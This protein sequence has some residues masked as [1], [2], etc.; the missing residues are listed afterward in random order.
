MKPAAGLLLASVV[1]SGLAANPLSLNPQRIPSQSVTGH[2]R[3]VDIAHRADRPAPSAG[4]NITLVDIIEAAPCGEVDLQ[5]NTL[6]AGFSALLTI[7]DVSDPT[8]PV[9]LSDFQVTKYIYDIEVQGS[10]VYLMDV[11]GGI[12][13]VDV[14]DL[15]DPILDTQLPAIGNQEGSGITWHE[16]YLYL[17]TDDHGMIIY[18]ASDP[19]NP[20]QVGHLATASRVTDIAV[21]GNSAYMTAFSD[22]LF[23]LDVTDKS[24]PV[25]VGHYDGMEWIA[26]S[27]DV[28]R[29]HA[30]VTSIFDNDGLWI[31][32][33]SDPANPEQIGFKY[34]DFY[35]SD[36]VVAGDYAYVVN[37][38]SSNQELAVIDVSDPTIPTR[39][40]GLS[41]AGGYEIAVGG[42]KAYVAAWYD[43]LE[44]VDVSVPSAPVEIGDYPTLGYFNDIVAISGYLAMA[45]DYQL[46]MVEIDNPWHQYHVGLTSGQDRVYDVEIQGGYAY[47][48]SCDG[49]DGPWQG[50]HVVDILDP[51][52]PTY[53]SSLGGYCIYGLSVEGD[54]VYF[55]SGEVFNVVDISDSREPAIVGSLPVTYRAFRVETKGGVAYVVSGDDGLLVIDV[56]NP[57]EPQEIGVYNP[58]PAVSDVAVKGDFAYLA[59]SSYSSDIGFRVIDISVPSDP[60]GVGSYDTGGGTQTIALTGNY[61]YVG[62]MS[63]SC[64]WIY[65]ISDPAVPQEAGYYETGGTNGRAAFS[66]PFV[67]AQSSLHGGL[68]ILQTDLFSDT[69]SEKPPAMSLGQNY[70]NPFVPSTKISFTMPRAARAVLKVYDIKGRLVRT[71]IDEETEKGE[72]TVIWDG[73]DDSGRPVA[74]GVYFYQL[75]ADGQSQAKKMIL[76]K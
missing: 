26:Y 64:L 55:V 47:L 70:P 3:P 57:T 75:K 18:D 7:I 35:P 2:S 24:N 63:N 29:D 45:R 51:A 39:V 49:W 10:I 11:D 33:V 1:F 12:W 37:I 15:Y 74:S 68:F 76:L 62:G 23:V 13:V 34:V 6:F 73:N 19:S 67:F 8:Q 58:G 22:G 16:S 60:V 53:V 31:F 30:Y 48:A 72:S 44:V 17:C 21:V 65:D 71:L 66:P 32:D 4:N 46:S 69:S 52:K 14:S 59:V 36:V 38:S 54:Y 5:G 43:G 28:A 61:V 27:I 56:S 20:V 42:G 50:M 25:E 9:K 41:S 40:G